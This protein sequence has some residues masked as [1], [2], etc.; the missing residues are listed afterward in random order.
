MQCPSVS[1]CG[2]MLIL[3]KR[4]GARDPFSSLPQSSEFSRDC[5][6]SR[7]ATRRLLFLLPRT[8]LRVPASQVE[9][10]ELSPNP[11]FWSISSGIYFCL[12]CEVWDLAFT[13]TP[14]AKELFLRCLVYKPPSYHGIKVPPFTCIMFPYRFWFISASQCCSWSINLFLYQWHI[15]SIIV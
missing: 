2:D 10:I 13:S 7:L 4:F 5:G 6:P 1:Q 8:E 15:V 11:S 3:E 9:S 14:R 12:R